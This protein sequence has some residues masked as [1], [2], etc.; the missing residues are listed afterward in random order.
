MVTKEKEYPEIRICEKR[1]KGL[2][3]NETMFSCKS[4]NDIID[5]LYANN[6]RRN[7]SISQSLS[8]RS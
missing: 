6:T 1:R 5:D 4:S 3:K 7:I 2:P 8:I